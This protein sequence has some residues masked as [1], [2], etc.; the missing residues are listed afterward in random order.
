VAI[1]FGTTGCRVSAWREGK[2]TS[3][4]MQ[5]G[6]TTVPSVLT[7][8]NNQRTIGSRSKLQSSF[9]DAKR[10]LGMDASAVE[11]EAALYPF[12]CSR[13][14]GAGNGVST[15]RSH[16]PLLTL[17]DGGQRLRAEEACAALLSRVRDEA[18]LALGSE[19]DLSDCVLSVPAAF[20]LRQRAAL[21]D[22]AAIAG[23]KV[24]RL[25]TE[26]TALVHT[27]GSFPA[28]P[29]SAS[30]RAEPCVFASRGSDDAVQA[31]RAA[32][33]V[34]ARGGWPHGTDLCCR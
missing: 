13:P 5:S 30:F 6:Q 3:L 21:L 22:A 12:R 14:E 27:L 10:F 1:D 23:L 32:R 16:S 33:A 26:T 9:F 15:P 29:G 25:V 4:S 7:F 8:D 19:I 20:S 18:Q 34:G 2:V 17:I 24:Q 11:H 31:A 28:L